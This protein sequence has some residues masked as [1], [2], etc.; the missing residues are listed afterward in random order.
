MYFFPV[1]PVFPL[2]VDSGEKLYCLTGDSESDI[3]L[4]ETLS[5]SES[6][7]LAVDGIGQLYCYLYEE[8]IMCPDPLKH[9][10]T[11]REIVDLY[12]S[13]RDSSSEEYNPTSLSNKRLISIVA[14]IA[15][16][17]LAA[18]LK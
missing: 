2:I 10:S 7:Y 5:G 4:Q 1:P 8:D 18:N 13:R 3:D 11:K 17:V 16:L 9:M 6:R 14:D 15:D 12:N